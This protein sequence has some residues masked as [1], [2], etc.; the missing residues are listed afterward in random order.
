MSLLAAL[1]AR[2]SGRVVVIGVGNPWRGDDG[3]GCRVAKRLAAGGLV[4]A[5]DAGDIPESFLGDIISARPD[6]AV[7]VDAVDLG[8]PAGSAALIDRGQLR[9]Y[10]PTTHHAPLSMLMELVAVATEA[11]VFLVAIQPQRFDL[12]ES[13]TIEVT[14]A[15]DQVAAMI[16][17]VV[18]EVRPV[19]A[20][21]KGAA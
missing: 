17:L 8:A 14:R 5:V 15:A 21:T 1:R 19:S 13:M 2:L 7:F 20:G 9:H 11:D 3:A 16:E 12:H 10:M 4:H 6:R 18:A